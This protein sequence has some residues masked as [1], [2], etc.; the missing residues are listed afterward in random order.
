MKFKI[1]NTRNLLQAI[2]LLFAINS[3]ARLLFADSI[4]HRND[5]KTGY[6]NRFIEGFRY[7]IFIPHDYDPEKKYHLVLYLH[8]YSDTTSWNFSWYSESVQH[9]FPCIVLTPKCP[10]TLTDGWGRSWNTTES[11]AMRMT[12]RLIDTLMKIDGNKRS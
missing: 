10:T 5:I 2:F 11:Y 7:G 12:F 3:N 9:E 1:K 4:S 8:G 6:E